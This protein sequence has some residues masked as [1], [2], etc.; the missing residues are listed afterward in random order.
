MELLTWKPTAGF[1]LNFAVH[2]E[3]TYKQSPGDVPA[4]TD[5]KALVMKNEKGVARGPC[6]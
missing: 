3:G 2:F 1:N 5:P 6:G 4:G